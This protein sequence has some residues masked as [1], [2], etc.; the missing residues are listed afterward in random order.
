MRFQSGDQLGLYRV[1][2]LLGTGAM[3]EVICAV[4][5]RLKRDVAIT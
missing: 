2:A 3:G 4:D 1:H 5:P